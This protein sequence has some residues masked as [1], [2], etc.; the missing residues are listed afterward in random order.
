M[1]KYF[2]PYD[3][4]FVAWDLE[5]TGNGK[6]DDVHVCYAMGLA[7]EDQYAS[8]G[9]LGHQS[10]RAWTSSTKIVRDLLVTHST[11]IT[12]VRAQGDRRRRVCRLPSPP[13]ARCLHVYLLCTRAHQAT[14]CITLQRIVSIKRRFFQIF[15]KEKVCI[16]LSACKIFIVLLF[17]FFRAH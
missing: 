5:C 8:F 7:W 9:V 12:V 17:V 16:P 11:R 2:R 6:E 1:K 13:A 3:G 4:K 14:V 10:S 15:S